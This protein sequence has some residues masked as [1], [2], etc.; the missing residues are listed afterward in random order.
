MTDLYGNCGLDV[1][2]PLQKA[3]PQVNMDD[4]R[5]DNI[6]A[7]PVRKSSGQDTIER[8]VQK[9]SLADCGLFKTTGR[10]ARE[11]DFRDTGLDGY[12]MEFLARQAE[13]TRE[14]IRNVHKVLDR[15]QAERDG[16]AKRARFRRGDACKLN[17]KKCRVIAEHSSGVYAV[18]FSDGSGE[19]IAVADMFEAD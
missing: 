18:T 16:L 15:R 13:K 11:V 17:G 14:A 2:R 7:R 4:I 9:G 8:T 12:S 1:P 3:A 10:A 19:A 5:L 6:P